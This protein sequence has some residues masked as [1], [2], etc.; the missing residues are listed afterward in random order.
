[1]ADQSTY[2]KAF[3]TLMNDFLDD[4]EKIF[5][6]DKL[7]KQCT[8]SIR[9]VRKAN[10]KITIRVWNKYLLTPY[11]KYMNSE[12]MDYFFDKDY[13]SDLTRLPQSEYVAESIEI[14]RNS[15][16]NM[17]KV[18]K[19]HTGSYMFKLNKLCDAYWGGIR[20][21]KNNQHVTKEDLESID[22]SKII[23]PP[24]T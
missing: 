24:R 1:M 7:I 20:I 8:T 15:I 10:P 6:N 14:M 5:P 11:E 19:E 18:N 22:Q 23:A 21:L 16:K 13:K 17:G 4:L 3:N 2:L 12:N 9:A